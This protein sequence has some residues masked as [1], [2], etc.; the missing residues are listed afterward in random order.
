[1]AN[2][3]LPGE[4]SALLLS[5]LMQGAPKIEALD[6]RFLRIGQQILNA[7]K[8]GKLGEDYAGEFLRNYREWKGAQQDAPFSDA[9]FN[10]WTGRAVGWEQLLSQRGLSATSGAVAAS[11][12]SAASGAAAASAASAAST[13][14]RPSP[15]S[16]AAQPVRAPAAAAL[17]QAAAASAVAR[18]IGQ[19]PTQPGSG[20]SSAMSMVRALVPMAVVTLGGVLLAAA[21]GR[22]FAATGSEVRRRRW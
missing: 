13:A 3:L 1:M 6:R 4:D 7:R 17:G 9:D 10:L 20:P 19:T 12:A 8:Q 18:S 5:S 16:V 21:T 14:A 22:A 15:A 11:A 2:E